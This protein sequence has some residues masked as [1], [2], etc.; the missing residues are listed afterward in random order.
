VGQGEGGKARRRA[1]H[2]EAGRVG[3]F[4]GVVQPVPGVDRERLA[5]FT[6]CRSRKDQQ[7]MFSVSEY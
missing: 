7:Y 5:A 3:G 4:R 2:D 6:G 1:V